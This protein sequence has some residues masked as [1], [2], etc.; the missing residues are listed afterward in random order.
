YGGDLNGDGQNVNDL[1][2]VPNKASD[3]TFIENK[4]TGT[5]LTFTP[6]Q[7]QEAF[8]AYLNNNE[9]LNSRRGQY[10][11]RNGGQFPWLTRFDLTA[12]QE[13]YIKVGKN[14]RKN[15]LQFRAD[16]LNFGNLLNDAW[17]VGY[18][19]TTSQPLTPTVNADGTISYRL[20]TQVIDGE[21]KLLRDAYV[22]SITIDNVWQAQL[23]LRYIFN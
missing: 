14:G 16:I 22:K 3:I 2:Y 6:Q 12:V 20:A 13:F 1:I 8:E 4:P 5:N 7:Q 9:Y 10:A 11:E 15:T 23:G 21:T 18:Q 19:T 17:G